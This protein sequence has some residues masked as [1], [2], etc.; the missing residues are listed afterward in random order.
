[1]AGDIGFKI[2]NDNPWISWIVFTS[3]AY[4]IALF[5]VIDKKLLPK[6][7]VNENLPHFFNIQKSPV[8]KFLQKQ[9]VQIILFIFFYIYTLFR[10]QLPTVRIVSSTLLGVV[11]GIL[12]AQQYNSK[13]R[14]QLEQTQDESSQ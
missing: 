13:A 7:P 8:H 4:I 12:H 5:I 1:M 3:F 6:K 2:L 11:F 9:P 14:K 10:L